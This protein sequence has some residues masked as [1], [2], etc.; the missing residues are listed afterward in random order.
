MEGVALI[1]SPGLILHAQEAGAVTGRVTDASGIQPVASAEVFVSGTRLIPITEA[2][3]VY[4]LPR[5]PSGVV[6]IRVERLGYFPQSRLVDIAVGATVTL[7][8]GA[9]LGDAHRRDDPGGNLPYQVPGGC[10]PHPAE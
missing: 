4:R 10:S 5:V 3:G 9:V 7:D 8:C 2:D 6:E 1:A